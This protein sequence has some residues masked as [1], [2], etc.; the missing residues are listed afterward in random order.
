MKMSYGILSVIGILIVM[1]VFSG[2]SFWWADPQFYKTKHL[3][4]KEGGWYVLEPEIYDEMRQPS[5][6]TSDKL[7]NGYYVGVEN[8]DDKEIIDSRITESWVRAWY[9]IDSSN[10]KHI[11]SY[12]RVFV[13]TAYGLWLLGDEGRG[14]YLKNRKRFSFG[15]KDQKFVLKD[16]KV[17]KKFISKDGKWVEVE[18]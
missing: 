3:G 7:S 1:V 12:Y 16:G 5:F 11:I 10:K 9:F 18:N 17:V 6:K 2:C 8:I 4:N 15:N 14:F 13:Y